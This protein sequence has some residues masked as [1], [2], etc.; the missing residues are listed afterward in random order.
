V[1]LKEKE[2]MRENNKTRLFEIT[3]YFIYDFSFLSQISFEKIINVQTADS[4]TQM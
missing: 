3:S 2:E 4:P 1:K